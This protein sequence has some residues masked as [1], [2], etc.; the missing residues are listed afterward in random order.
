MCFA[1][2]AV[3]VVTQIPAYCGLCLLFEKIYYTEK[4]Y[5]CMFMVNRCPIQRHSPHS[6]SDCTLY[7]HDQT[8]EP[9]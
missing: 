3:A 8:Q 2:F 7:P 4:K 5:A 9:S 6:A 1:D